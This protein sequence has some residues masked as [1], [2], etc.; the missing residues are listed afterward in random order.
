MS[1]VRATY[2]GKAFVPDVPCNLPEGTV[3]MLSYGQESFEERERSRKLE[4]LK[5]LAEQM[6]ESNQKEPLPPEFDEILSQR[7]NIARELDL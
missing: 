2:D 7:V 1:M 3:V 6:A 5:K 4:A